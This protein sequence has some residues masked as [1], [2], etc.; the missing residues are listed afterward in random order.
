MVPAKLNQQVLQAPVEA[1]RGS[2]STYGQSSDF[3][4]KEKRTKTSI[5]EDEWKI[6]KQQCVWEEQNP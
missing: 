4:R 1:K 5:T 3:E 2:P 6:Q